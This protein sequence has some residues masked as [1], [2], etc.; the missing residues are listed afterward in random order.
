LLW[1]GRDVAYGHVDHIARSVFASSTLGEHVP[2]M[3]GIR[4][5]DKRRRFDA[6][7]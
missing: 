5:L 7:R 6:C 1:R 2:S 4:D 3:I